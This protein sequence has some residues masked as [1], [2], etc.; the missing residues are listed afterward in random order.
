MAKTFLR[1]KMHPPA[2]LM[3]YCLYCLFLNNPL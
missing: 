2:L 3:L 1:W